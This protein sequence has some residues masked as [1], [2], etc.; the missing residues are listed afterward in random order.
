MW[1]WPSDFGPGGNS[2][3]GILEEIFDANVIVRGERKSLYKYITYAPDDSG[4][5]I[6]IMSPQT[7]AG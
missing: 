7:N 2:K 5:F 3:K 4:F 6:E 1:V